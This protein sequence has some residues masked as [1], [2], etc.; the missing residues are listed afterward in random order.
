MAYRSKTVGFWVRASRALIVFCVLILWEAD[1]RAG[2]NQL[3]C[4]NLDDPASLGTVIKGAGGEIGITTKGP[5]TICLGVVNNPNAEDCVLIYQ[6]QV[7]SQG[8]QGKAYLEMWCQFPGK[9]E[10]FSRG[11]KNAVSGDTGW[12]TI[13]TPFILQANQR[14]EAVVLSIAIAGAGTVW[15][16]TPELVK[17]PKP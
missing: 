6:A 1:S 7:K 17:E 3:A 9:G 15:V 12:T 11:L 10:Y 13:K 4:L 8:L 5:A 2:K 14:P 16:K